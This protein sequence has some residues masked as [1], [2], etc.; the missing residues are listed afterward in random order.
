[1]ER[2]FMTIKA[3]KI[4][5][6]EAIANTKPIVKP[7][8]PQKHRDYHMLKK[9]DPENDIVVGY[10][11]KIAQYN[12]EMYR[13]NRL[14]EIDMYGENID[15]LKKEFKIWCEKY[16]T[17]GMSFG[18]W[19][20]SYRFKIYKKELNLSSLKKA[21]YTAFKEVHERDYIKTENHE[22]QNEL[23]NTLL[24]YTIGDKRFFNSKYLNK[25]MHPSLQKGILIASLPGRGKSSIMKAWCYLLKN[26]KR[27][28]VIDIDN[29]EWALSEYVWFPIE[30]I[31][32]EEV[33]VEY[34]TKKIYDRFLE[35]NFCFDGLCNEA[36]QGYAEPLIMGQILEAR[37]DGKFLNFGTINY[38]KEKSIKD[39]ESSLSERY[40]TVVGESRYYKDFNVLEIKIGEDLRKTDIF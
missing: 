22:I 26:A 31:R 33:R 32:A 15:E 8:E 17:E 14:W 30:F 11:K 20:E 28:T 23:I 25:E 35:C 27:I 1:M 16:P 6:K 37:S 34:N 36:P 4:L 2:T 10:E 5:S 3:S 24:Y 29:K 19:M 9:I 18:L 13:Y 40:G 21:F 39:I 12:K 38:R 7:I